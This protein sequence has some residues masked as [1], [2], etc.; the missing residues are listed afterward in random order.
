[1]SGIKVNNN[2]GDDE[3]LQSDMDDGLAISSVLPETK[4]EILETLSRV[5][6]NYPDLR[7]TQLVVNVL[8]STF[9]SSEIFYVE[10]SML[11]NQLKKLLENSNVDI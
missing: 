6:N 4:I 11:V 5:W 2:I 1:M 7:L 9:S 8:P 10:D 3:Y